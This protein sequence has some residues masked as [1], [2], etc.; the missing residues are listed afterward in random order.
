M[1]QFRNLIFEGGGVKGIAYAGAIKVLTEKNILVDI[2]R[3]GGTSAGAIT[4]ALLA[5]GAGWTD[6]RDIVGGTDFGEFM[7][8]SWGFIRNLLRLIK[9]FG[10]CNGKA[11]TKWMRDQIGALTGNPDLT[12]ADLENLKEKDPEKFRSLYVV[13]TN[14]SRQIPEVFSAEKTPDMMIG[15]AVRISMGIPLFF[16]AIL[17][18]NETWVDGGITWNYP[19]DI[20]DNQKYIS[21]A[22]NTAE[23]NPGYVYNKET[24]GF[25]VDTSEEIAIMKR[26]VEQPS[27]RIKNIKQYVKMTLGFMTDIANK[28]HLNENDWHRT[29][30]I[31]AKG[32]K[33]T[34]FGLS[35]NKIAELIQSGVDGAKEYFKWFEDKQ[36]K[37]NNKR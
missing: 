20:F 9:K 31:D 11:F 37:P 35:E 2:R 18:N 7:D 16:A 28:A 1:S 6:I 27:I 12:F 13:G 34:D 36:Q 8:D 17:S 21:D 22:E 25:R 10:L 24:L 23:Y 30:F 19:I 33:T 32:V 14:L 15:E 3:V 26:T 4:A 5:L 29:V